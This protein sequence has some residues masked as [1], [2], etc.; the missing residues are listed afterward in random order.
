MKTK[1]RILGLAGVAV[2]ATLALSACNRQDEVS[3]RTANSAD[4]PLQDSAMVAANESGASAANSSN[5][6]GDSSLMR[7][8]NDQ[9]NN[10]P[11]AAGVPTSPTAATTALNASEKKFLSDAAVAGQYELALAQLATA[12]A[13]D[14]SVKSYATMLVS[15]HTMANQKLQLLAQRRNVVLPTTLP[16]DKQ[17]VIDRLTKL[18]GADFDRQFVQTV[19]LHDHKTDITLFEKA[20]REAKDSEVRDFASSTLPTL[21]AHLSAAQ[22]LPSNVKG[23]AG[24]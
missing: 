3:S 19:G 18:T 24:S 2:S 22:N 20:T 1:S 8:P 7:D 10:Q 23:S 21:R 12:N 11:T 13:S 17:E 14:S 16:Q 5:P 15:D 6:T 4:T 9:L